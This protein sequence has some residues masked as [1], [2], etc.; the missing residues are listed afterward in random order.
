MLNK[1]QYSGNR[2][3]QKH[4]IDN[5]CGKGAF[6][7]EAVDRYCKAYEEKHK[8]DIINYNQLKT[9]LEAFIHGIEIDEVCWGL[10]IVNLNRVGLRYGL[11]NV[12]WDIRQEDA[13]EV[14]DF[15]G[16][17]DYVVGNP[18]YC[19]VHDFGEKYKTIKKF[20]FAQGGMSD[21]YLVFFEIGINMLNEK[22]KLLYITPSSWTASIAGKPFRKYLIDSNKLT[23]VVVFGHEKIFKNATTFTMLTEITNDINENDEDKELVTIYK[24]NPETVNIDYIASR[25]LSLF[26][27]N[28]SFYFSDDTVTIKLLNDIEKHNYPD[29][30]KVKNGFATLND[31]LFV[32]NE[33]IY[34]NDDRFG[35]KDIIPVIKASTGEEKWMVFPYDRKNGNKPFKFEELSDVTREYLLKRAKQLHMEENSKIKG[36][37]WLYGRSQAINDYGKGNRYA[38]NNLIRRKEDVKVE[39]LFHTYGVYSG[40]Y[41]IAD[42]DFD[43]IEWDHLEWMDYLYNDEFVNYV[44]M[45]GRYK[46]GGYYTFT[47]KELQN[48]LNYKINLKEKN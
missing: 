30:V 37:W 26:T 5:S 40:F 31:K 3:L 35:I 36:E 48:Y 47:T 44:K 10:T 46:N 42:D 28:N 9:E 29:K 17:M 32:I 12:E 1:L 43:H 23:D 20:S 13:L 33:W 45:L 34:E 39:P 11:E 21:L 7:V 24:Y 38:I 2:V 14:D 4:I 22:G 25:P 8:H 15:N 18:P 41:I 6:L 27:V 19:N 16:K